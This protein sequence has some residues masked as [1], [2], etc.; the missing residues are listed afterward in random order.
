[1][2]RSSSPPP[3]GATGG[4]AISSPSREVLLGL[5]H[6]CIKQLH[7][8]MANIQGLRDSVPLR[9]S[10]VGLKVA[11]DSD[12]TSLNHLRDVS[13]ILQRPPNVWREWSANLP[14]IRKRICT[15]VALH[16]A[17]G[18]QARVHGLLAHTAP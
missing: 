8:G 6:H 15:D 3:S 4:G 14:L 10:D 18:N 2:S 13:T 16:V 17:L 11:L 7:I 9:K 12:H 1:M 5:A